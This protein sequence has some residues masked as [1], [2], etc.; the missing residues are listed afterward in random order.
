MDKVI[1]MLIQAKLPKRFWAES[2]TTAVYIVNKSPSKAIGLKTPE[3]IWSGKPPH[4]S[5]MKIF[6]CVAYAH[7]KK[8]KLEPKAIK[9]IFIGYPEG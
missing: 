6:G 1:C 3:E 5:R 2:V 9:G 4:L 8:G 7:V